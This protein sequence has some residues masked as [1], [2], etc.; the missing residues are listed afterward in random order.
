M[1]TKTVVVGIGNE[2]MGDDGLGIVA[3]RE[4]K[5]VL[6]DSAAY[7]EAAV[8][9]LQLLEILYG[10]QRAILVDSIVGENP[11]RI[12]QLTA[13]EVFSH[14]R[15]SCVH[16]AD[17]ATAL[18]LARELKLLIPDEITVFAVEVKDVHTF[19]EGLS[20]EIKAAIPEL[21]SRI[22]ALLKET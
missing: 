3:V 18:A 22:A 12:H 2:I 13:D 4:L 16:D 14:P 6:P 20:P 11:G 10:Y 17:F 5:R 9:G 19:R 21:I 8:G 15:L 1:V 7:I